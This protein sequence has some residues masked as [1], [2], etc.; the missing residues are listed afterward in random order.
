MKL[1]TKIFLQVICMVLLLSSGIFFYTTYRWKNQS[2]Q[3]INSYENS[4]FQTNISKFEN[5]LMRI[6][7]K[8]QDSDDKIREKMIIYTF[9]QVFHDSAVLY[10][11]GKEQY[12]GTKYEFD[13]QN[14]R[15]LTKNKHD[16]FE[17]DIYCDK[18][19]ISKT[20]GN[21]FL[22][23]YFSSYSSTDM[24]YQIVT[25]KDITSVQKQSQTLF[26]QAGGFTL[27]LVLFVGFFLFLTLRKIMEPLTRLKEAAVSVANGNYEIKVPSE[28]KTE[29][30]QVGKSF[31]LMTGKV[32]E[33]IEKLSSVNQA[34]RQLLGSLAHELKTPITSMKILADSLLMQPDVPVELYEEFMNDIVHEIDRENQIITDLLTLVKMDKTQAN[35]NISSVKINDLLEVLLKRI[36]PIAEKRGIK[37]RLETMREVI[38]E[39]DEVKLSLACNNLIEN[40]VKYNDDNGSVDVSLNADHKFF[41]IRVKDTGCGIPEDCQEQIFERFYLVDKARSRETGGTGLGLAITRNVILMH[42][43]SIR[44]HSKEGEGSTFIIRIP[45]NYIG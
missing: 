25:Y 12:N 37:I 18:P 19:L 22:L 16:G 29:L 23:F 21:V 39:V 35:L 1:F 6:K 9:R 11:D 24:N 33:Q 17:N 3:N 2:I 38:A 32:R 34:Q 45:L 31:N 27:F 36:S 13:L 42:K 28:G 40:A 8:T 43:G 4:R 10:Q 41:Y 5:M 14:I 7:S 26:Y 15:N 30:A 44:V 20:N